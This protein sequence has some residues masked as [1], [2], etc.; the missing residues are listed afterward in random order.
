MYEVNYIY[1][2]VNITYDNV[3]FGIFFYNLIFFD[4]YLRVSTIIFNYESSIL[5]FVD[6]MKPR[7]LISFIERY[8]FFSHYLLY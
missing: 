1:K 6:I 5:H 3:I 7:T 4:T 2:P 8:I